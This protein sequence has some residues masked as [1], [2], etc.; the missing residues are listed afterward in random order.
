MGAREVNDRFDPRNAC[1]IA[2]NRG[3]EVEADHE[4]S[5][6]CWLSLE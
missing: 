6:P 3:A 5:I 2:L 4:R 1:L